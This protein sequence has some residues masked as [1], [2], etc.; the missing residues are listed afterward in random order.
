LL[1]FVGRRGRG[2][3]G[4]LPDCRAAARLAMKGGLGRD[5]VGLT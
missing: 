4:A 3:G 5:L 2:H 1:A